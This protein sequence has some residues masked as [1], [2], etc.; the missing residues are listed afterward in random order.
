M[1]SLQ[2]TSSPLLTSETEPVG[3]DEIL[4]Y[5]SRNRWETFNQRGICFRIDSSQIVRVA[6]PIILFPVQVLISRHLNEPKNISLA[7]TTKLLS[8]M[9]FIHQPFCPSPIRS[10]EAQGCNFGRE[11][12]AMEIS[13]A[14]ENFRAVPLHRQPVLSAVGMAPSTIDR[15][16]SC[17]HRCQM[18][19]LQDE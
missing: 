18:K 6:I 17:R 11:E 12:T 13:S 7:S 15:F 14:M 1:K 5:L 19:N 3:R 16:A 10:N 2:T 9:I 4:V 8:T